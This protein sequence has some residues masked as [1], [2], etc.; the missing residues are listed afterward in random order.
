MTPC[1]VDPRYDCHRIVFY[2]ATLGVCLALAIVGRFV[3]ATDLEVE[4]FYG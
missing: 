4:L 2:V 1:Y 3:L